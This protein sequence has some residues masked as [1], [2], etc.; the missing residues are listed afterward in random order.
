MTDLLVLAVTLAF[1]AL[2]AGY[3]SLCDRLIGPDDVLSVAPP[4]PVASGA[5]APQ[6]VA[7]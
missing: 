6:S 5:D 2:C 7:A 1:F 3:I 4:V